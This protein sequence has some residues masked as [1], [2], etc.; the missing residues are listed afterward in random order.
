MLPHVGSGIAGPATARTVEWA[1]L[2]LARGHPADPA[3]TTTQSARS[4]IL[5]KNNRA[6]FDL[7][8]MD[9]LEGF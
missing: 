5:R 2:G 7:T 3:P 1:F 8:I 6:T 9:C 4:N